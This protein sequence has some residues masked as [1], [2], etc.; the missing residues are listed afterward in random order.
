MR[1]VYLTSPGLQVRRRGDRLQVCEG[2]R[3]A[4]DLRLFD[5]DRLVVIGSVQFTTQALSLLLDAGIDVS[6][7]TA[8]GRMRGSLV[9]GSSANVFLR[10]AQFERWKDLAYRLEYTRRIVEAKLM[11]QQ[12]VLARYA[13]NHPER[14][15]PSVATDLT[16]LVQKLEPAS[17]VDELRGFEGAGAAVYYRHFGQMLHGL[18]FP[19]RKKHPSTDPANSLLSLG[20]TLIGNELVGLLESRGLDPAVGFFHGLRYGRNSLS[21]DLI[22]PFRQ[23]VID[24]L[25]LRLLNRGQIGPRDFEGG[26][27][28]LRLQPAVLKRFLVQYEETLRSS[29]EGAGS[30]SWRERLANDVAALRESIMSGIPATPYV[31]PG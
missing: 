15:D 2:G 11:A 3:V 9:A 22:E 17:T 31:W 14:V 24:R 12:R 20:Y 4:E 13:R 10:L 30:P 18:P 8:H 27:R 25:T 28:G 7:M 6:F 5:L 1:I 16:A 26:P 21:L 19:G 29:S 23:P